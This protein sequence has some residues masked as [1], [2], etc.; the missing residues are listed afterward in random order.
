MGRVGSSIPGTQ[1]GGDG[2]C[3]AVGL[4]DLG[5][6]MVPI[7]Q[8]RSISPSSCI[9]RRQSSPNIGPSFWTFSGFDVFSFIE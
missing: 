6:G 1:E 7:P 4:S 9:V 2:N 3:K 5:P 8:F